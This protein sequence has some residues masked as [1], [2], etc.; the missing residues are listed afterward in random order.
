[1]QKTFSFSS[2]RKPMRR[3]WRNESIMGVA[4]LG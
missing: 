3:S 1:M 4:G 2:T